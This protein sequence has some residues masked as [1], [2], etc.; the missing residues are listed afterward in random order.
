MF[1]PP[2]SKSYCI[3]PNKMLIDT[4]YFFFQAHNMAVPQVI[5]QNLNVI[6]EQA[7]QEFIVTQCGLAHLR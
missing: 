5:L 4:V 3:V 2:H 7:L 1:K 6:E